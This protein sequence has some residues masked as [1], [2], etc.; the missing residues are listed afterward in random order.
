MEMQVDGGPPR[1]LRANAMIGLSD[2]TGPDRAQTKV[3]AYYGERYTHWAWYRI[4]ELALSRGARALTL[5]AGKGTEFDALVVLPQ[6][7]VMDRAAV[8]LFQNWNYAPWQ[9][10]F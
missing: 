9:N 5:A 10:P 7:P 2:W 8:N 1:Q 6:T 3:Y 4:P